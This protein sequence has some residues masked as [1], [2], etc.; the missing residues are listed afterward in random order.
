MS[1]VTSGIRAIFSDSRVFDLFQ[2]V[3]GSAD[4][5]DKLV[6]EYLKVC[7]G[8]S[9]LD[10][11]CGTAEILAHLPLD[12]EYVGFDLSED[13]INSARK[14][15]PNRGEFFTRQVGQDFIPGGRKFGHVIATGVLHHLDDEEALSL[16][17]QARDVMECGARFCS[18]DPC[19]VSGQS[20]LSKLLVG[21]DRGQNVRR[22]DEY[23]ELARKVFDDVEIF[24]RND[25]LRVPYDHAILVCH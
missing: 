14:K 17:M 16:F 3:I 9:I 5:M 4:S 2:S 1:Q 13:Y 12:I 15:F 21:Y 10:I 7:P 18:I 20:W 19:F 23:E 8:D 22:F 25:M 11:G 6:A 24:H